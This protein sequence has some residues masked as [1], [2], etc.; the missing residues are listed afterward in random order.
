MKDLNRL[1][2]VYQNLILGSVT[3]VVVAFN[4]KILFQR[5]GGADL[6]WIMFFI[7]GPAVGY[8][9]GKERE[10]I[11]K[12]KLEK[13]QLEENLTK[14][15]NTLK[16]FTN[17][18]QLL[19]EQAN[20]AIFLTSESGRF[21]LFN[22]STCLMTGHTRDETKNMNLSQLRIPGEAE[23]DSTALLDNSVCRYEDHWKTKS[24]DVIHLE[25]NAKWIK[26]ADQPLILNI[27]RNI[28]RRKEEEKVLYTKQLEL[29]AKEKLFEVASLNRSLLGKLINPIAGPLEELHQQSKSRV[30]MDPRLTVLIEEWGKVRQNLQ[31][32]SLK[33]MRDM[34]VSISPWDIN[35]IL[36]QEIHYLKSVDDLGG[37][38]FRTVFSPDLP[39]V[40]GR[41]GDFS[42]AFGT[43]LK[44][45][46]EALK[47][48][49]PKELSVTTKVLDVHVLVELNARPVLQIERELSRAIAPVFEEKGIMRPEASLIVNVCRRFF[50]AFNGM[51]DYGSEIGVGTYFKIRVPIR[52]EMDAGKRDRMTDK[53]RE[54]L[55]I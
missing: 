44:A 14:I 31:V 35:K 23:R 25:I 17:K 28:S 12:M 37:Y 9:S 4:L 43:V 3:G 5:M 30:E 26:F 20:D 11:E 8:F 18:Y 48:H 32:L 29:L 24:G 38:T 53:L 42:L 33:N 34:N 1:S 41:G 49:E 47:T 22:E 19:V 54:S 51:M 27:A 46:I 50:A 40:Y 45:L 2:A 6:V 15:Q 52:Q 55:I 7:L 10:R 16:R 36:S 39:P 13:V 21:L